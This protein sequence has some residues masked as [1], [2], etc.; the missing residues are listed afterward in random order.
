M[1][2]ERIDR[3]GHVIEIYQLKLHQISLGRGYGNDIIIHDP[4][5]D[6]H[7]V[8]VNFDLLREE[9]YIKDLGSENGTHV[10]HGGQSLDV[11]SDKVKI[12]AGDEIHVGK[13]RLRVM[14]GFVSV[15]AAIPLSRF[16][17]V[18][19]GIGNWVFFT[20]ALS[21]LVALY[22]FDQYLNAPFN[23]KLSKELITGSFFSF[24][25]LG[26]AAVWVLYAKI[27]HHEGHFFLHANLAMLAIISLWLFEFIEPILRFNAEWL[28]L[29]GFLSS[30]FSAVVLFCAVMISASQFSR[31]STV[32]RYSV[33]SILPLV[34]VLMTV[35]EVIDKPEY[36]TSPDYLS[37][38]VSPSKQWKKAITE[39]DFLLKAE[40]VFEE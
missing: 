21:A 35:S 24:V 17:N 4:Y 6:E 3:A 36:R 7:H 20:V 9:F 23:E 18:Y 2:V 15:P 16:E 34:I 27:Q 40:T 14:H 31:L 25:A 11:G 19:R 26:Y 37:K 29:G 30:I 22:T 38:V 33:A 39:E 12:C 5:V 32:I 1:I 10:I 28:L 13:T 8:Q